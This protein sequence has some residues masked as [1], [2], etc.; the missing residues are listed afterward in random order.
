MA[1]TSWRNFSKPSVPP[2]PPTPT[3]NHRRRGPRGPVVDR[4]NSP[5]ASVRGLPLGVEPESA[6]RGLLRATSGSR[7]RGQRGE[8]FPPE[9]GPG[10]TPTPLGRL[11]QEHPGAA[12][13]RRVPRDLR[14]DL[15]DLLDEL[16]LALAS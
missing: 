3:A 14:D 7:L 5:R 8:L 9:S 16:L 15:G 2:S 12:R 4:A 13:L 1:P 10:E 6:P 11:R